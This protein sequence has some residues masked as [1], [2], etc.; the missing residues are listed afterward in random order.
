MNFNF[1]GALPNSCWFSSIQI[2]GA[3]PPLFFQ[4]PLFGCLKLFGASH[5]LNIFFPLL[6]ILH[7]L[8]L[9]N[10]FFISFLQAVWNH[11]IL[12]LPI[13]ICSLGFNFWLQDTV[14]VV[15]DW[16]QH[17]IARDQSDL[18]FNHISHV[19][20]VT[21]VCYLLRTILKIHVKYKFREKLS[22]LI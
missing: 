1:L 6:V 17:F 8:S 19:S 2:F 20:V 10:K 21:S 5:P 7:E 15:T 4:S 13:H 3:F 12:S 14:L 18:L 22:F 11:T 9:S 16:W